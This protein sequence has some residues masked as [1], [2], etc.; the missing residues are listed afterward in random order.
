MEL[1]AYWCFDQGRLLFASEMKALL[2]AGVEP[3]LDEEALVE[4]FN[5]SEF[6]FFSYFA[7]R[8]FFITSCKRADLENGWSSRFSSYWDFHFEEQDCGMR[9]AMR[10]LFQQAVKRQLVADVQ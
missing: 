7:E 8:Y 3:K 5:I 4:Y 2:A 6:F 1:N 9:R 10:S